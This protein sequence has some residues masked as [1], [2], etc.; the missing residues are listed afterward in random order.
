M[1]VSDSFWKRGVT[2]HVI[3]GHNAGNRAVFDQGIERLI[4][5]SL[6]LIV[7]AAHGDCDIPVILRY[8]V[9]DKLQFKVW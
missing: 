8:V 1:S 5:V 4:D 2:G 3:S 6:Q 7:P 9:R